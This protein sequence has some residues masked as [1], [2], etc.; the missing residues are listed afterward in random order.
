MNATTTNTDS[1]DMVDGETKS[2]VDKAAA[3]NQH[4]ARLSADGGADMDIIIKGRN[5]G[6]FYISNELFV[7][8]SVME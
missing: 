6:K 7:N 3:P 5:K 2:A 4:I 1:T 8:I